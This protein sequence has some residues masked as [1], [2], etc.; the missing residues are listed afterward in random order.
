MAFQPLFI[1]GGVE[2]IECL[3]YKGL[4]PKLSTNCKSAYTKDYALN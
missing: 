2:A 4:C 3:Q 1:R